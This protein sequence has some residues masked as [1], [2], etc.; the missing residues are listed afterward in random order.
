ME[1]LFIKSIWKETVSL[2]EFPPLKGDIKTDVLI[3]GGGIAGILTAYFLKEQGINYILV[4]GGRI[5]DRVTGNTT[6]KITSQHGLIYHKI[7]RKY[8]IHAAKAYFSANN[9]AVKEYRK[10]CKDIPCDYQLR[11]ACVYAT[12][13]TDKL[14]KELAVLEQICARYEYR[15]EADLPFSVQGS[16]TRCNLCPASSRV[17]TSM[18]KPPPRRLWETQSSQT[19]ER[20]RH[21]KSS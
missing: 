4:S 9:D 19:A 11:D 16:S 18:S 8:G 2:P 17:C 12:G 3:I 5:C 13:S 7:A 14:E 20:S 1:V 10:L 15:D 21:P 6:A